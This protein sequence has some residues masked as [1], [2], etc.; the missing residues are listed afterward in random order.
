MSDPKPLSRP[1]FELLGLLNVKPIPL[2]ICD[3]RPK[4]EL[5]R[6]GYAERVNELQNSPR[7]MKGPTF[8]R[9]MLYITETGRK[10]LENANA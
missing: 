6:A 4:N 1:A 9:G 8:T 2:S 10:Y 5:K 7:D 3:L